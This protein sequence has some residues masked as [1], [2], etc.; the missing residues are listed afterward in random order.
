MKL[1]WWLSVGN[2]SKVNFMTSNYPNRWTM[3]IFLIPPMF[4]HSFPEEDDEKPENEMHSNGTHKRLPRS[5]SKSAS[6]PSLPLFVSL[7]LFHTLVSWSLSSSRISMYFQS[8]AIILRHRGISISQ[9]C[10]GFVVRLCECVRCAYMRLESAVASLWLILSRPVSPHVLRSPSNT[11]T[12]V[13]KLNFTTHASF[14]HVLEPLCFFTLSQSARFQSSAPQI[15]DLY[16]KH[17]ERVNYRVR[18]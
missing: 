8:V 14:A 13:S 18:L 15:C 5:L 10:C 3:S 17:A 6:I 12:Q 1:H 2:K 7:S 4:C 9:W 16:N 11:H